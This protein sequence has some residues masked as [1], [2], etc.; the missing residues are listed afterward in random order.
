MEL[1]LPL[2]TAQTLGKCQLV[3]ITTV[4]SLRVGDGAPVVV[5]EVVAEGIE[6]RAVVD[7]LP[8]VGRRCIVPIH[9]CLGLRLVA[10][11]LAGKHE[12]PG[13]AATLIEEYHVGIRQFRHCEDRVSILSIA[14]DVG[15]VGV[16]FQLQQ[17]FLTIHVET[18]G[19]FLLIDTGHEVLT[20]VGVVLREDSTTGIDIHRTTLTRIVSVATVGIEGDAVVVHTPV[21]FVVRTST[22]PVATIASGLTATHVSCLSVVDAPGAGNAVDIGCEIH[23]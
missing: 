15:E 11:F 20:V 22:P 6:G 10:L 13:D 23:L 16:V 12:A 9:L 17:D 14:R 19:G 8:E 18:V 2:A 5:S 7:S 21:S 1:S 4:G 3:G